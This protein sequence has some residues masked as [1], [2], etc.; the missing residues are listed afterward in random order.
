MPPDD[1]FGDRGPAVMLVAE[2]DD[3]CSYFGRS[4]END[5]RDVVIGGVDELS[6]HG[7]SRCGELVDG[8]LHYFLFTGGDVVLAVKD[9]EP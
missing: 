5:V 7:D 1:V 8:V 6:V 3:I 9:A 4:L 2:D